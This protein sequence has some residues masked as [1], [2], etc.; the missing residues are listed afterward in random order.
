MTL[1]GLWLVVFLYTNLWRC[2]LTWQ[3]RSEFLVHFVVRSSRIIFP[4]LSF[5]NN[6]HQFFKQRIHTCTYILITLHT[7]PINPKL[8]KMGFKEG[9]FYSIIPPLRLRSPWKQLAIEFASAS[10]LHQELI[11]LP[12][13]WWSMHQQKP[14]ISRVFGGYW[15]KGQISRRQPGYL[16]RLMAPSHFKI[17]WHPS[18]WLR[19]AGY[20]M[21]IV[22]E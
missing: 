15:T 16:L 6:F 21:N 17:F 5:T 10:L 1:G 11:Q 18:F 20:L 8:D 19:R 4:T 12:S 3:Q 14:R 13:C 7:P 9:M 2:K 22:P